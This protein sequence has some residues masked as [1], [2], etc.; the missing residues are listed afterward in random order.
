MTSRM[1]T[2]KPG[3]AGR[4]LR[5]RWCLE[6]ALQAAWGLWGRHL[7]PRRAGPTHILG[8]QLRLGSGET[9]VT[10]T[11]RLGPA[12]APARPAPSL[13]AG[14]FWVSPSRGAGGSLGFG[15]AQQRAENGCKWPRVRPQPPS[16]RALKNR[17]LPCNLPRARSQGREKQEPL[18]GL[19]CLLCS[20][21]QGNQGPLPLGDGGAHSG[22]G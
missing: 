5:E 18:Q 16:W 3:L 6:S 15:V 11:P 14:L 2:R 9:E 22:Q 20:P 13:P 7:H 17:P 8:T 12:A 1:G 10:A 21:G 19:L 4:G